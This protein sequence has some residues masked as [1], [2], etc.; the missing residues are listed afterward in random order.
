MSEEQKQNEVSETK[1]PKW[2]SRKFILAVAGAISG[3]LITLMP[4]HEEVINEMAKT[5]S[6][7]AL[8]VLSIL[9]YLGAEAKIDAAREE[10]QK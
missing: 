6:G 8:T 9:G 3:V 10:S 2:L 4:A 1:G 7:I 5:V